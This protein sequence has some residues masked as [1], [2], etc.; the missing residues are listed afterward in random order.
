MELCSYCEQHLKFD[1]IGKWARF[2]S[3]ESDGREDG[4]S[5]KREIE[6][7]GEHQDEEPSKEEGESEYVE[8]GAGIADDGEEAEYDESEFASSGIG[9]DPIVGDFDS[10]GRRTLAALRRD[11]GYCNFCCGLLHLFREWESKEACLQDDQSQDIRIEYGLTFQSEGN[12]YDGKLALYDAATFSFHIVQPKKDG[13]IWGPKFSFH[14]LRPDSMSVEKL[15]DECPGVSWPEAGTVCARIRPEVIDGRL[16]KKWSDSCTQLHEDTCRIRFQGDRL[17]MLRVIDVVQQCVIDMEVTEDSRWI[18]LSYVWGQARGHVLTRSNKDRLYQ[19]GALNEAYLPATIYDAMLVTQA[20]QERFLWVDAL[21]ILQDDDEDKRTF[22]GRMDDIYAQACLTIINAAGADAQDPLP[23]VRGKNVRET[24]RAFDFKGTTL[25]RRLDPIDSLSSGNWLGDCVWTTRGWTLQEGLLSQR[26]LIFT[27]EQVYW[28][29][30]D[31]TWCEDSNWEYSA[32][33]KIQKHY[34]NL[35]TRD[36]SRPQLWNPE[37]TDFDTQY[38]LFVREYTQRSLTNGDDILDAIRGILKAMHRVTGESFLWAMPMGFMEK[39]LTWPVFD[40]TRGEAH[41]VSKTGVKV[42]YPSWSWVGW[43]G[44]I[45]FAEC[46]GSLYDTTLGLDFYSIDQQCPDFLHQD[47]RTD[48]AEDSETRS[49]LLDHLRMG[50]TRTDIQVAD[51][52]IDPTTNPVADALLCF[53]TST[54]TL[55]VICSQHGKHTERVHTITVQK[56]QIRISVHFSERS[57]GSDIT[58]AKFAIIAK[59]D[60]R[61]RKDHLVGMMLKYDGEGCAERVGLASIPVSAWLDLPLRQW[62]PVFL[63]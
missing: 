29:C 16:F 12:P 53:W 13:L 43:K 19:T 52:P 10:E 4:E 9:D 57:T 49:T 15:L 63:R 60:A 7:S 39:A 3:E 34:F 47:Y 42:Q 17:T 11:S 14:R 62:E 1:L 2:A 55:E 30:Q 18:A 33:I 41:L 28:Q 45:Y 32:P 31:A 61:I 6:E 51:L 24:Q 54:A 35:S 56:L 38:Q 25:V 36:V 59:E 5:N 20:M 27:P 44:I 21:C 37:I 23:G 22:I 8:F 26:A 40:A 50:N 46:F 58:R 48:K